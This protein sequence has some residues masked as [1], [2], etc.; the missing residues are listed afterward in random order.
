MV[1]VLFV[2]VENA[3][4]SQMA[5]GLSKFYGKGII[6]AYSAGSRPAEEVNKQAVTVMKELGMDISSFRPKGFD[7][8][9]KEI[10]DYVITLGCKDTCP[11]V[12]AKEHITWQIPDPKGKSKEEFAKARDE[13]KLK[14]DTFINRF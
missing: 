8:F 14:I 5:E 7:A 10:F 9:K 12:P 6:D 4:R 2:C 11:F 13:I 1:K 3:C